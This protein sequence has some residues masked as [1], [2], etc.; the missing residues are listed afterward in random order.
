MTERCRRRTV[1]RDC[2]HRGPRVRVNG[3]VR[4]TCRRHRQ[5][6]TAHPLSQEWLAALQARSACCELYRPA[7]GALN[8]P[9]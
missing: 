5:D 1:C 9:A 3:E 8:A 7:E 2:Q 4:P 6:G